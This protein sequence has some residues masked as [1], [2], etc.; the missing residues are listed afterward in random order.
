VWASSGLAGSKQNLFKAESRYKREV[1]DFACGENPG[2]SLRR[3]Y[4]GQADPACLVQW[5]ALPLRAR[6]AANDNIFPWDLL[7]C[8]FYRNY[9]NGPGSAVP[10]RWTRRTQARSHRST[11]ILFSPAAISAEP[12]L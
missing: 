8:V 3:P 7:F 2:V 5:S 1:N 6:H 10:D 12:P 4:R 9:K 11:M